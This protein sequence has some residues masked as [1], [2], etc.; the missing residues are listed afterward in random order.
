LTVLNNSQF[1][2]IDYVLYQNTA[3]DK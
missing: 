2:S 3:L 1:F